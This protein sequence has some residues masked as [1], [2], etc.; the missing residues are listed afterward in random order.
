MK[1]VDTTSSEAAYYV[2]LLWNTNHIYSVTITQ[3][4]IMN[5][6]HMNCDGDTLV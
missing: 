5:I 4:V 3:S 6:N 1:L 2:F